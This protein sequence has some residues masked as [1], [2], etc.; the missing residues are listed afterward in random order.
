MCSARK[1]Q[2]DSDS[3]ADENKAL[4]KRRSSNAVAYK[5]ASASKSMQLELPKL[6]PASQ[7][8]S[9]KSHWSLSVKLVH[10]NGS[11]VHLALSH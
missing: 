5:I 6:N 7:R 3:V 8:V 10:K 4:H 9:A 11:F 1:V 2:L